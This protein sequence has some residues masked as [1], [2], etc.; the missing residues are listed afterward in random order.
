MSITYLGDPSVQELLADCTD[1]GQRQ[2]GC[3]RVPRDALRN[4]CQRTLPT[5]R[6]ASPLSEG[7]PDQEAAADDPYPHPQRQI[8]LFEGTGGAFEQVGG[9]AREVIGLN[10]RA[11]LLQVLL[12]AGDVYV[13]RERQTYMQSS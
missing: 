5:V 10:M 9:C 11:T 3:P 4:R 13:L 7:D 2:I 12:P 8:L 1:N 6:P